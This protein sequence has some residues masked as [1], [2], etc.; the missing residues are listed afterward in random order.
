[1]VAGRYRV[2]RQIGAGGMGTVW[3]AQDA[4]TKQQVAVKVI[5]PSA[6][7]EGEL[8]RRF[9]R[10]ARATSAVRHPNVVQVLD[11][12]DVDGETPVLV[13][14]L[15]RGQT[16]AEL[17]E[18]EE[19]LSVPRCAEILVPAMSA[20][21]TAHARGIVHR[22][23]KPSNVFLSVDADGALSVKVLDFG[24]A[25]LFAR[26]GEDAHTQS[27]RTGASVG[28]PSYLSPEQATGEKDVN[29][30]ADVWALGVILYECLSG[31]R[32]IEGDTVGQVVMSLMS[33]GITPLEHLVPELPGDIA[34]L[35]RRMLSREKVLR[36]D[37][38]REPFEVLGRYTTISSPSFGPPT[39][40]VPDPD[41]FPSRVRVLPRAPGRPPGLH[42]WAITAAGAAL[43][44]G[45]GILLAEQ[46]RG[47]AEESPEGSA[48]GPVA[49]DR[50]TQDTLAG[51][52]SSPPGAPLA[53]AAAN[54][55][56]HALDATILTERERTP[57]ERGAAPSP[58]PPSGSSRA[59]GVPAL[60]GRSFSARSA[61]SASGIAVAAP[62][63][64]TPAPTSL[65]TSPP[66][67]RSVT[68]FRGG[69]AEEMPF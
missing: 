3:A 36:P 34:D 31:F 29:H 62:L 44:A 32:P 64:Q 50:T 4:R 33:T 2:E 49:R 27:T 58:R 30:L 43:L 41:E 42:R 40:E 38:L 7:A 17:L 24:I 46:R 21:G 9:L 15:L 63:P 14:E 13:M 69:L 20:V 16:L 11:A 66:P 56:F 10:E 48:T 54:E 37:D 65:S 55:T 51:Q 23:L 45:A 8:R 18:R 22:D 28:T 35:A 26:H 6:H 12:I 52:A 25:K 60:P 59:S 68:E 47:G 61:P 57:T 19:R 1:M 39:S 67:A 53:T 5:R